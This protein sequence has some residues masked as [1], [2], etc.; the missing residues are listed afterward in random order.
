MTR[1]AVIE[2]QLQGGRVAIKLSF[3][4]ESRQA[5]QFQRQCGKRE[6]T[7]ESCCMLFMAEI[8]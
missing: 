7:T 8:R 1:D 3:G 2:R 5:R 4:G 6:K